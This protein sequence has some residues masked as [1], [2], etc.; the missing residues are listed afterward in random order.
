MS[1]LKEAIFIEIR[2]HEEDL[3]F[4][5]DLD[6]NKQIFHHPDGLRLSLAGFIIVRKIFTAYSFELPATIKTRHRKNLSTLTYPYYFTP[7]RLILFSSGDALM[8]KLCGGL[9]LFLEDH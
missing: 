7:K 2:K 6:L 4:L 5:N 9:E 1:P 8:I 3:Q